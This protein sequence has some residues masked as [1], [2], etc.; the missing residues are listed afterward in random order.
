MSPLTRRRFLRLLLA[1]SSVPIAALRCAPGSQRRT[2]FDIPGE[3]ANPGAASSGHHLRQHLPPEHFTPGGPLLDTIVIGGGVSGLSACWKLRRAGVQ[4]LRLVEIEG[5][6]GGTSLAGRGDGGAFPWGAHYINLP[7]AEADCIHE[8]LGDLGIIEGYDAEGRPIVSPDHLLRWPRE[9]LFDGGRWVAG[10][11]PFGGAQLGELRDFQAFEDD[12]LGWTLHRG[13]DQR[14]AFAMPLAYSTADTVVREL[15]AITMEEYVR[16]KG[17]Q[18]PRLDWLIN[19]ACR[20]D[21]GALMSQVSAWAGIHYF[22]CRFYDQRVTH[23]YPADTLTWEEG[24][25]FLVDR[26]ASNLGTEEVWLKTVAV[27]VR[28]VPE[29]VEVD[30][31]ELPTGRCRRLRARSAVYA[32]KLHA[33]PHV[34]A[35]M[36]SDQR[37][38]MAGARY[39]AWLVA[40]I[41]VS[42]LPDRPEVDVCWDNIVGDS[43]SVGYVAARHQ[44][45]AGQQERGAD[46][47][48]YYLP[49]V[50]NLV[51]A[52]MA[53]RDRD[54]A[55]WANR[56]MGDLLRV[57]PDL[58][59]VVERIDVWR[60]GHAMTQPRPGSIWGRGAKLRQMPLGPVAFASCDA[61]GL[62]LFEEACFAGIRAAE[63]CLDAMGVDHTTS[64]KGQSHD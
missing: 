36:S 57:H 51:S 32:G 20:D 62:P 21:Y 15:D 60:W 52:R 6:L 63:H 34:I 23:R 27:R 17:W 56:V 29:G 9:R 1:G 11:D 16:S 2:G 55:Y 46:V 38:A 59:Q 8:I 37:Q 13:R 53:L 31:L 5:E 12:M 42:A 40:A 35:G 45:Q 50:Q 49:F 58:D 48:V 26:L 61:T 44:A 30:C 41:H 3:I 10:L 43:P 33:A 7:P 64:L 39:S 4:S 47:L 28:P 18:S 54:Q 22:A 25:A 24:N 14:R 19:Y